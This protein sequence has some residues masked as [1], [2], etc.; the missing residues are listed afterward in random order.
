MIDLYTASTGNGRRATIALEECGLSYK[1]HKL[2]LAQG[3][4][5]KPD[6]LKINPAA[7]VPA[8][9]D[10]DG[11]GGKALMLA[12]SGAIVLYCAEKSGKLIPKDPAKRAEAYQWFMQA[13][14]DVAP[15][16]SN[17]FYISSHV[18]VKDPANTAYFEQKLLAQCAVVDKQLQG[19]DYIAG[20]MSIADVAL[21]PIVA[22]RKALI[23]AAPGLANLKA[24]AARMAA[25]PAVAKAIAANG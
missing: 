5:K 10:P 12:Q 23:D 6:F 8:I 7:A 16:S 11:P 13:T 25:R 4:A 18:P 21:Y 20:E 22:G 1:V 14:T 3:D 2:D 15:T 24:W 9:V 19:R 17:I